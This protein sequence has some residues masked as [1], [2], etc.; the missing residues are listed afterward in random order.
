[1]WGKFKRSKHI[2]CQSSAQHLFGMLCLYEVLFAFSY[3]HEL[4][5]SLGRNPTWIDREP[6]YTMLFVFSVP[7]VCNN[8]TESILN[9]KFAFSLPEVPEDDLGF[10][11]VTLSPVA[12]FFLPLRLIYS[13]CTLTSRLLILANIW[14][15]LLAILWIISKTGQ[16]EITSLLASSPTQDGYRSYFTQSVDKGFKKACSKVV[17]WLKTLIRK[18][19]PA[20][21]K[22]S[23]NVL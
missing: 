16:K 1:M 21:A 9:L 3:L 2:W 6:D 7:N 20:I 4:Q 14:F 22:C 18:L 11:A 10:P 19:L 17:H 13:I 15:N 12:T 5:Y 8:S 23:K